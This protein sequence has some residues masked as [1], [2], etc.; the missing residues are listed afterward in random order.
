M[1]VPWMRARKERRYCNNCRSMVCLQF[2]LGLHYTHQHDVAVQAFTGQLF[3]NLCFIDRVVAAHPANRYFVAAQVRIVVDTA[4][5]TPPH[6]PS[7]RF[8]LSSAPNIT[9][10]P[11]EPP[12]AGPTFPGDALGGVA[13]FF[14][15]GKRA[16]LGG[17]LSAQLVVV[18][19]PAF[20]TPTI[21][22]LTSHPH[23]HRSHPPASL[24]ANT[25]FSLTTL[26]THLASLPRVGS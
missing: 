24:Y 14:K 18:K 6:P 3:G 1:R 12:S 23:A 16:H 7:A 17:D 25:L 21:A 5:P 4:E 11:S 19:D 10:P 2:N 8:P 9:P 15:G 13:Q 20:A 26:L 22:V